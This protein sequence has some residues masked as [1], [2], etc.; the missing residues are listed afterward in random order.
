M[1][2]ARL[3]GTEQV[4]FSNLPEDLAC[5]PHDKLEKGLC[6][7]HDYQVAFSLVRSRDWE[8]QVGKAI[9]GI[10]VSN[11]GCHTYHPDAS[12]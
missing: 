7:C 1:Q 10:S 4:K 6:L 3:K 12:R 8:E 2:M 5:C 11:R 9:D